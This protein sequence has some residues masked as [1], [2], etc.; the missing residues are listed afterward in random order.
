MN[1]GPGE[2][3]EMLSYGPASY[4]P[5]DRY[6]LGELGEGRASA[7]NSDQTGTLSRASYH[8][9]DP[10]QYPDLLDLPARGKQPSPTSTTSTLYDTARVP[11]HPALHHNHHHHQPLHPGHLISPPHLHHHHASAFQRPAY[12]AGTLPHPH[13]PRSVS[14]DHTAAQQAPGPY[15]PVQTGHQQRPGYVTLPRRPRASWA[16]QAQRDTPSPAFSL[17]DQRDPVYDGVGPRTSADGSSSVNLNKSVDG[18]GTMPR[19]KAHPSLPPYCPP[20][21]EEC[22]APPRPPA[23]VQFN[24]LPALEQ[25]SR[26]QLRVCSV[27]TNA[28]LKHRLSLHNPPSRQ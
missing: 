20:I 1:G 11:H 21:K 26:R 13:H 9:S 10:D 6:D 16:G 17:R 24:G 2:E 19:Q 3:Q 23:S 18:A 25:V 15:L 4:V 28:K 5:G 27:A 14:C 8:S 12:S 7:S 22:A